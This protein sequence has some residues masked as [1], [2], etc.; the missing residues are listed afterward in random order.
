[1]PSGRSSGPSGSSCAWIASVLAR[2]RAY[3][4]AMPSRAS[5]SSRRARAP[6]ARSVAAHASRRRHDPPARLATPAPRPR[7]PSASVIARTT[8]MRRRAALDDLVHVARVEPADREPRL[9][10]GARRVLDVVQSGGRAARL[11]RRRVDRPDREVVD[12]LVGLA[13]PR[14]GRARASSGRRCGPGRPPRGRSV[15]G[16][17]SWPTWMPSAPHAST[18]SGRSLRMKSASWP[19]KAFAACT[20]ASSS[21]RLV[22]Q[23]DQVDAAAHGG[24][25]PV[26]RTRGADEVQAGGGEALSWRHPP[27]D[28]MN[29]EHGSPQSG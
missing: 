5:A 17:S 27:G 24:R 14:P 9:R 20:S 19:A 13:P 7:G 6:L 11:G 8:T 2:E 23:L 28:T 29:P 16:S 12:V 18:R 1:M 10:H 25:D 4:R 3:P 21:R 22:A 26:P 15:G